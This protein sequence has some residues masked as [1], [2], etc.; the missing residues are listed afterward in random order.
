MQEQPIITVDSVISFGL[1][2]Q[3]D[4]MALEAVV[5]HTEQAFELCSEFLQKH[6]GRDFISNIKLWYFTPQEMAE[7]CDIPSNSITPDDR[8]NTLNGSFVVTKQYNKTL[9]I[10]LNINNTIV[11]ALTESFFI[12]ITTNKLSQ[13][14]IKERGMLL[15]TIMDYIQ[16]V[17]HE[18]IHAFNYETVEIIN[19]EILNKEN[20]SQREQWDEY[21]AVTLSTQ[22]MIQYMEPHELESNLLFSMWINIMN[23]YSDKQDIDEYDRVRMIGY[24][25][26]FAQIFFSNGYITD[27]INISIL[28][29]RDIIE[30]LNYNI[31]TNQ[32]INKEINLLILTLKSAH[33]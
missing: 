6:L 33:I 17:C 11:N 9:N 29:N 25:H 28:N 14:E 31:R 2:E 1:Q 20:Q 16:T 21:L 19:K 15:M 13:D 27:P 7:A 5:Y 24:L 12:P 4:L 23:S 10:Y 18:L 26:A 30:L 32:D 3:Y 22:L 8:K